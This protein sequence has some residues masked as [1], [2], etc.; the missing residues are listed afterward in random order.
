MYE[1]KKK[2]E[3]VS[4]RLD[5]FLEHFDILSKKKTLEIL[6]AESMDSTLW[7]DPEKAKKVMQE[8]S[9][10]REELSEIKDIKETVDVLNE[11]VSL[12]NEDQS[13]VVEIDKLDKRVSRLELEN[14]L[15]GAYDK[16]GAIISLHA[17]QGGTEAMD[18]TAMLAR[19][20][21]RFAERRGWEW[22]ILDE[23]AGD[24]A[25]FK[26]ITI[27][28]SGKY[29]YGYLKRESGA[30]RLVRQSPFN[31]DALRQTSFSLVE[32]M[33]EL[34]DTDTADV[35]IKDDDIEISFSRAG[36][37][38]GQNV[39]KVSTAVR[40]LHKP[41]GIVVSCRTERFQEQNRKYAMN[42][43]RAKLWQRELEKAAAEKKDLKGEYVP[44]TWGNQIRS[45][46]LHPYKM[47][48]DLRTEVETSDTESVLDGD[49]EI[50]IEAELKIK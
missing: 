2:F 4:K 27:K 47:V 16:K 30:H 8:L 40:I 41:T 15:G 32:V 29:C 11:L 28:I 20:Y 37:H 48:K 25:G 43:L 39:N 3:D 24:E 21:M 13:V 9:S 1:A 17:G 7:N 42:M 33:P 26:S 6:E 50:F 23:T 10:L 36:G 34:E 44:A 45:Y 19:M 31:A 5:G 49:L 38:G 18:W 35:E 46:V 22:E 12:E 14:Y